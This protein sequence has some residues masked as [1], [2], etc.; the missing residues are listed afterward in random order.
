MR[1]R[2]TRGGVEDCGFVDAVLM[3]LAP[4]RGLLVPKT[5]PKVDEAT[6]KK[7]SKLP[8]AALATEIISLYIDESEISRA[9]L[10]QL[11]KTA[12]SNWRSDHVT[13][14][15]HLDG[16]YHLLELFHG[17]TYAFKDVALQFLGVLFELIPVWKS[18]SE[19]GYPE[20]Y[21]LTFVNLHAIKQTQL[22]RQHRRGAPE[23]DF[24]TG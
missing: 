13:P 14:V 3:G 17:P 8:F 16:D 18:T 1:Y 19:L 7:W 5:I 4:D 11:T 24:H 10:E 2:S 22:R 6:L 12:Y 20:K 21:C 15:H 9:E 23:I